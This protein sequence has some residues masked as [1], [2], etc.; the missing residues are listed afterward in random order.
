MNRAD[1]LYIKMV[2]LSP[3][4]SAKTLNDSTAHTHWKSIGSRTRR[5]RRSID[6]SSTEHDHKILTRLPMH[7]EY[8]SM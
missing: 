8:I 7:I 4:P 3:K 2:T 6:D 5:R 1:K